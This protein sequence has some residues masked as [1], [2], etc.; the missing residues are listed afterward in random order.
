MEGK[1]GSLGANEKQQQQQ[2]GEEGHRAKPFHGVNMDFS[3]Y[4][5]MQNN[6]TT[7][8]RVPTS[9]S[10]IFCIGM[11]FLFFQHL[12]V[13]WSLPVARIIFLKRCYTTW[14]Q[15]NPHYIRLHGYRW[16]I[17]GLH[18]LFEAWSRIF[19]HIA[20]SCVA[21]FCCCLAILGSSLGWLDGNNTL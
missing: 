3:W 6:I 8:G 12:K 4:Y 18:C 10:C 14:S 16:Q 20:Q 19:L 17:T 13:S 1:W 7:L 2:Q 11:K 9:K 5:R 15:G 21:L